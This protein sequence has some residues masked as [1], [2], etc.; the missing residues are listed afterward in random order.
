[1]NFISEKQIQKQRE[2]N[3][4]SGKRISLIFYCTKNNNKVTN[5]NSQ[6]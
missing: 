1:M 3:P 2:E 6:Y 5:R 4:E